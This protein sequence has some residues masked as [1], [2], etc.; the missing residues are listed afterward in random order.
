[1]P[2]CVFPA[3][4]PP[5]TPEGCEALTALSMIGSKQSRVLEVLRK[6]CKS[7]A[8]QMAVRARAALHRLGERER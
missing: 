3:A 8:A 1:M 4:W 7:P 5:A 6:A 2:P